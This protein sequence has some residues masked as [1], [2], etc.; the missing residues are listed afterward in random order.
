MAGSVTIQERV[1]DKGFLAAFVRRRRRIGPVIR[2]EHARPA[3]SRLVICIPLGRGCR[4]RRR[5]G[6]KVKRTLSPAASK[7]E[8][9]RAQKDDGPSRRFRAVSAIHGKIPNAP[10][11]YKDCPA[12]ARGRSC[13]NGDEILFV[14]PISALF[15]AASAKLSLAPAH[16]WARFRHSCCGFSPTLRQKAWLE[17]RP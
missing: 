2:I 14:S 9:D 16:S 10:A 12:L 11:P 7:R 1:E 8:H 6:R 13:G 3:R 5:V 17:L 4:F 15:R